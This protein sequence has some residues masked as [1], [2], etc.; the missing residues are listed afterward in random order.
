ME[1]LGVSPH[2]PANVG[3]LFVLQSL[4][5]LGHFGF[6]INMSLLGAFGLALL[7]LAARRGTASWATFRLLLA[8]YVV[9][10]LVA[11]VLFYSAYTGLFLA[12]ARATAAGGLSGMQNRDA[13]D[14]AAL[15]RTLWDAGFRVHF[16]FFPVP[17][18]LCGLALL[19]IGRTRNWYPQGQSRTL[20]RSRAL[21]SSRFAVLLWLVVGTF[22]VAVLFGALPFVTRAALSTRWLMFSAWAIAV[23]AGLAGQELWRSGRAGKWATVAM[24]AYIIWVS[25][26]MWLGA[27]AWRI[28][29]PEPF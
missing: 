7:L 21:L 10:Q 6:W 25:A 26:S 20:G 28:R 5:Y 8:A 16:G 15:W 13:V 4:V 19:I 9:A 27:L 17:L 11:V 22:G 3:I 1:D 23:C 29:P 24:A 2:L 18:A 12:Q 14:P